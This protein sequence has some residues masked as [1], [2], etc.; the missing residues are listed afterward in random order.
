MSIIKKTTYYPVIDGRKGEITWI[1]RLN[2][3]IET[4]D[5]TVYYGCPT[6]QDAER[7]AFRTNN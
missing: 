4:E 3:A 7:I 6:E 2:W 5:G 1:K